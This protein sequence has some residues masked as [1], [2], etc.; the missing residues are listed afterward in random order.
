MFFYEAGEEVNLIVAGIKARN[1]DKSFTAGVAE[2]FAEFNTDLVNSL[3]TIHRKAGINDGKTSAA[4]KIADTINGVGLHP[5]SGT[6]T[7]LIRDFGLKRQI[8]NRVGETVEGRLAMVLVR[9][10]AINVLLRQTVKGD[11]QTAERRLSVR[12]AH[13]SGERGDVV[14]AVIPRREKFNLKVG[15]PSQ[16]PRHLL[17]EGA[18]GGV[19]F[20]RIESDDENAAAAKTDKN[21]LKR[22]RAVLHRH[23]ARHG[24]EPDGEF[25]GETLTEREER[26]GVAVMVPD[27]LIGVKK[28]ARTARQNDSAQDRLPEKGRKIDDF[29]VREEGAEI[30]ADGGFGERGGRSDVGEDDGG[31]HLINGDNDGDRRL[32]RRQLNRR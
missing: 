28:R 22:G 6:E 19:G 24:A 29:A 1:A 4:R 21:L 32:I 26:R 30:V 7:R 20:L 9:T 10:A 15:M 31:L 2:D 23:M 17:A 8:F 11:E 14:L 18:A 27:G 3:K 16:Q 13:L 12:A 5:L 25:V